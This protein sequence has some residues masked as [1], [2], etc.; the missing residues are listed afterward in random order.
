MTPPVLTF[1]NNKGG[2]GKTS[3]IY[4]LAWMFA[5]LRKRVVIIDLDPQSN[6]TAAFLDEEDIETIWS[7][8]NS[9]STIYQCV[10]PLME[11][12][13]IAEP[14]LQ[15]I[16]TDLYLLPGDV[17]L[18]CFEDELS[19]EWPSSMGDRALYR[20]MRIISAF[21]QVMQMAAAKVQAD[22][23]LVDIG[24]NLGAINRSVLIA[25]D[26]VVIPLGA[27]LFSLQGLR[28]LGPTLKSWKSSWNKRLHNWQG[29]PEAHNYSALELPKGNMKPIGYLCQQHSVRLDRPVKAYDK[30]VNRIPNVY[31]EAV[32][33][34]APINTMKQADD[35]YCLAI[36]KHYR[37][38]MPMAQEHRKAIFNLT[39][40]DGAIGSHA[41]AVQ[42]AK[43]DFRELAI[44]IAGLIGVIL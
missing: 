1:F 39:P 33:D 30:W 14:A 35:P 10:K 8:Q 38:L 6:L 12:N 43:K 13:D 16:A 31:R 40:A 23:I 20:P 34:E 42:D 9:G 41:S 44:R 36:I 27:D 37:S 32:L 22:I 4:H 11:V 19:K 26:Y 2:V 18:S 7:T 24:P 15:R 21:W 29:S 5:S 25:T 17:D 28:N 3:L